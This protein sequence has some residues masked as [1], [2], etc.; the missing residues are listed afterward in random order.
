MNN[1]EARKVIDEIFMNIFGKKCPFT[2]EELLSKFA[3]DVK[4]PGEV[5]DSLTGSKTWV[6]SSNSNKYIKQ[7]NMVKYDE[8]HGWLLKKREV[9]CLDDIIKIWNRIN[10]TTTERIY[11]SINISESDTIYDCENVLRSGDCRKCKNTIFSDGCG[12]SEYILACQRT[13]GSSYC[14]RV[15]DSGECSNSYN[16]ICS[17]KISNSFFIQDCNTLYECMFCS[18]ISNK[19]YCIANMQFEE[20]EYFEI[21]NSIID[22]ILQK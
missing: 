18:H 6:V 11:N 14:I 4:L 9:N 22:W 1:K 2:Y 13:G 3:F 7:S 10:Y 15:D 20:E 5:L 21:K 16:V 17:G 19:R 12:N 8:Q